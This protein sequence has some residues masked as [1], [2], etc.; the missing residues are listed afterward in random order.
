[1]WETELF[2]NRPRRDPRDFGLG[3]MDQRDRPTDFAPIS[4]G[5]DRTNG[6][7]SECTKAVG[8]VLTAK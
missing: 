1:M 4:A 8:G 2:E 6:I 7:D 3:V 5:P